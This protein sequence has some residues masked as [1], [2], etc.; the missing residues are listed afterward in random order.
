M[1][2]QTKN[3][4]S[5]NKKKIALK[6]IALVLTA[7]VFIFAASGSMAMCPDRAMEGRT[8][9]VG[10]WTLFQFNRS[11]RPW[12][13]HVWITSLN[14]Y[15]LIDNG[16]LTIPARI[17]G[18]N[19]QGFGEAGASGWRAGFY[20]Q[21]VVVPAEV[22]IT[23]IFWVM[24]TARGSPG[25]WERGR[26]RYVELLSSTFENIDFGNTVEFWRYIY[27]PSQEPLPRE[28]VKL[29]IIPD[30]ST[31]KFIARINEQGHT[32]LSTLINFI[33]KSQFTQGA[34]N[35]A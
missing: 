8:F 33:E 26:V 15:S 1:N 7:I 22:P 31:Q 5:K 10:G 17:G 32:N 28:N 27:R 9:E 14:D 29:I 25:N 23:S 3:T 11:N 30:G 35:N 24:D 19:I 16:V 12:S 34:K 21:K 6:R 18:H 2:T 20:T 13:R 4:Q